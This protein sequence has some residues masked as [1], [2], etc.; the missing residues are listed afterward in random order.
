MVLY[1]G[2]RDVAVPSGAPAAVAPRGSHAAAPVRKHQKTG[3]R[4]IATLFGNRGGAAGGVDGDSDDDS[5]G[6][7][8]YN[9]LF[10]G[11]AAGSGI[12]VQGRPTEGPG[13][14]A[15]QLGDQIF[16]RAREMGAR[17]GTMEDLHGRG[18]GGTGGGRIGVGGGAFQGKA[19]KL[20]GDDDE[21]TQTGMNP[22]R[23]TISP[24]GGASGAAADTSEAAPVRHVITVWANGVFTVDDGEARDMAAPDSAAF[25]QDLMAGRVPRE[26]I[27]VDASLRR[28][29]V[30]VHLVREHRDY[31][32]PKET[33][34]FSGSANKLS[35]GGGNTTMET[36]TTVLGEWEGVDDTQPTTE[37]AIRL[38]DG[39][40]LRATFNLTH[41][42][43]DVRRYLAVNGR[44][45]QSGFGLRGGFPPRPL[46]DDTK[47]IQELNLQGA[48]IVQTNL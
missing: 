31:E 44:G 6:S 9:E 8:D 40:R 39:S 14:R 7:D 34:A 37:V 48:T 16:D 18:G 28:R 26:L 32:K 23:S 45:T 5:G 2:S 35:A 38:A 47:T 1:S 15:R 20:G 19:N 3:H 4:G 25:M 22:S 41:T 33:K 30:D 11:G 36:T 29:P 24:G 27:P 17:E 13:Q 42:I 21:G 46:T 10:T 43:A 12:A